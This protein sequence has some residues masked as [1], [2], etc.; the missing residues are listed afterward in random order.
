[1]DTAEL[2]RLLENVIR[3]G[4]VAEIDYVATPR[5]RVKTGGLLTTWRPW[6]ERRAGATRTWCPPTIGEQVL[7]LC[8]SGDPSNA[9]V[10][11][12]I[13]TDDNDV[14][15]HNPAETVTQYPDGALVRYNHATG[16]LSVLGVQAVDDSCRRHTAGGVEECNDGV[17]VRRQYS[18]RGMCE[19]S[20]MHHILSLSASSTPPAQGLRRCARCGLQHA[21]QHHR[22]TAC[23]WPLP[24]SVDKKTNDI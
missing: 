15:S 3:L 11:C 6:A 13:S 2:A 19:L 23:Y 12:G 20:V 21:R 5:V 22:S 4:T 24:A 9:I 18:I 14:P 16:V 1:M 17:E 7:L 10:L 8:P